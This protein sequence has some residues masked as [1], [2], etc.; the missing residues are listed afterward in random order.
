MHAKTLIASLLF[1]SSIQAQSVLEN[2]IDFDANGLPGGPLGQYSIT[3]FQDL[4][5][6]DPTSI[7]FDKSSGS[8]TFRNANIDEG[9]DWFFANLNDTFDASTVATPFIGLD[10]SFS[11]P[12]FGNFYLAVATGQGFSDGNPNRTVRGWARFAVS[13]SSISLISSA[14]AYDASSIQVGTTNATLIP[15]PSS[16]AA[17]AGFACGLIA[18][19]RRRKRAS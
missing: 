4:A 12:V 18:C 19:S 3:I 15:E 2:V 6:T 1:L 13:G 5:Q 14:V 7:F 11:I 9:S 8:I 16:F 17:L 10:Q